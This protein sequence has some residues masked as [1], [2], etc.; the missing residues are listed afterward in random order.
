MYHK[1]HL[2]AFYCLTFVWTFENYIFQGIFVKRKGQTLT[3]SVVVVVAL[4]MEE[5]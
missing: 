5:K 3:S 4:V 2:K 1:Q